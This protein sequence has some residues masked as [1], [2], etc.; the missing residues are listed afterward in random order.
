MVRHVV[1][2]TR[3]VSNSVWEDPNS[4][5][6]QL[7][8]WHAPEMPV[9][10]G[11]LLLWAGG[12]CLLQFQPASL[13]M[14]L[15]PVCPVPFCLFSWSK[16]TPM[17]ISRGGQSAWGL[18]RRKKMRPH[19]ECCRGPKGEQP[20]GTGLASGYTHTYTHTHNIKCGLQLL[21][22]QPTTIILN[23][24]VVDNGRPVCVTL[25]HPRP[26]T[27]HSTAKWASTL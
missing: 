3:P 9:G 7:K 4:L 1:Q 12:R 6:L 25:D 11:N 24:N 16:A 5:H 15:L 26:P 14:S 20:I 13:Q 18:W 21:Q 19:P 17:A 2:C 22:L 27:H 10:Q 8:R 23:N